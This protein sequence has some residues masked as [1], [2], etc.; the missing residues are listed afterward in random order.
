MILWR[1]KQMK[2]NK[3]FFFFFLIQSDAVAQ[4]SLEKVMKCWTSHSPPPD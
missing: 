4:T 2:A 3:D 1:E